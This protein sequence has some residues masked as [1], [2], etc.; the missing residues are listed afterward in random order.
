MNHLRVLVKSVSRYLIIAKPAQMSLEA[1]T[2]V[3]R[4]YAILPQLVDNITALLG[5]CP[6]PQRKKHLKR[7]HVANI[8]QQQAI[9][10]PP[11]GGTGNLTTGL[12]YKLT[13]RLR[14]HC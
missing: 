13:L 1:D 12:E 7:V 14:I 2:L 3:P 5:T 11:F 6:L 9:C 8:R 10:T 4:F